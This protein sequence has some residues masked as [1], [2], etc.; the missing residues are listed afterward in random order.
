MQILLLVWSNIPTSKKDCPAKDAEY[1]NSGK[2]GYL[3]SSCKSK[4]GEKDMEKLKD[5][6]KTKPEILQE[7]SA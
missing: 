2:K 6:R 3:K 7:M 1:Y 4:K 5:M